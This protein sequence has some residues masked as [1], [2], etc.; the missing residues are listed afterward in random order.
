MTVALVL[1]SRAR[2]STS[3]QPGLVST[4][5]PGLLITVALETVV[6]VAIWVLR[7]RPSR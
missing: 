2:I 3:S 7:D 6:A 4:L 5:L 1:V